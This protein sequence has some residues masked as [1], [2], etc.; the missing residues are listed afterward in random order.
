MNIIPFFLKLNSEAIFY[1]LVMIINIC[2]IYLSNIH[3][4]SGIKTTFG[5]TLC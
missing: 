1:T 5:E 2:K 4:I 3:F